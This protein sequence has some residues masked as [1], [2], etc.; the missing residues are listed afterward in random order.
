MVKMF[1][2][3]KIEVEKVVIVGSG[4]A[5]LTAAIYAGRAGLKPLLI[6]GFPAGGQL[7][8]TT[9]VENFPGYPESIKGPNLI[10]DLNK[11]AKQF[12]T[13]VISDSVA[14]FSLE[15]SPKELVLT[16]GTVI[17]AHSVILSTGATARYLGLKKE[18]ELKGYGVSACA[19]CDG[20]FYKNQ[21]VA[22]IG[23]GDS[24]L[25]DALFLT[26]HAKSI[27]VV[28]RR[29]ELR[30]SKIMAKRAL[31]HKKIKFQW[32]SVV[33]DVVGEPQDKGVVGV[34]VKNVKTGKESV[35]DVTGMF[36]AIG[37]IPATNLFKDQIDLDDKGFI[38]TIERSTKT[39]LPGVFAAGDV[40]DPHYKQAIT[41]A[42]SGCK[43]ALDCEKWLI[44]EG[45]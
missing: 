33:L 6:E 18:D 44:S 29:D 36:V 32:D 34:K 43:A 42:G 40:M 19:V 22:V 35:L 26:N 17:K 12:D 27:T 41:A 15:S 23:G 10:E 21:D 45:I 13:R 24:A 1:G 9:E 14:K 31:E 20:F 8:D 16:D 4:P 28:H 3:K 30:A 39:N 25:E 7:M 11:Q 2:K 37:H 38:Q 5:G